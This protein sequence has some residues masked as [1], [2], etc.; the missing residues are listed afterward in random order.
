MTEEQ[1]PKAA[2]LVLNCI[3]Q[4]FAV[5][6]WRVTIRPTLPVLQDQESAFGGVDKACLESSMVNLR[7]F[8]DFVQ[9]TSS[10]ADDLISD[11]FP[12]LFFDNPSNIEEDERMRI[13]KL[14]AHLTHHDIDSDN[15]RRKSGCR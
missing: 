14:V 4:M 12:G 3:S 11:N 9:S 7:A 8:C 10:R 5:Y 6:Y 13:N 15:R 1:L 2:H